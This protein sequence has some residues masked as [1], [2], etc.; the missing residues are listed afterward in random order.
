M[1]NGCW[2]KLAWFGVFL[3]IMAGFLL[4]GSEGLKNVI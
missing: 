3:F 2:N 4:A 1:S